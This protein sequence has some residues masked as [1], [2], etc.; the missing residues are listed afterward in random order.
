MPDFEGGKGYYWM[1]QTKE[2]IA[3]GTR[4]ELPHRPPANL[5]ERSFKDAVERRL[6]RQNF[7]IGVNIVNGRIVRDEVF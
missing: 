4:D 3:N 1:K 7:T 2:A 6:S 5:A